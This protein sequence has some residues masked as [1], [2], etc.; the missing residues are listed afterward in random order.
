MRGKGRPQAK[1]LDLALKTSNRMEQQH[2]VSKSVT[3][4]EYTASSINHN[5]TT[6]REAPLVPSSTTYTPPDPPVFPEPEPY[7]EGADSMTNTAKTIEQITT[8]SVSELRQITQPDQTA[9]SYPDSSVPAEGNNNTSQIGQIN[10]TAT[11]PETTPDNEDTIE[12]DEPTGTEENQEN[13]DVEPPNWTENIG[14]VYDN[15]DQICEELV[16]LDTMTRQLNVMKRHNNIH[17]DPI[18]SEEDFLDEESNKITKGI[19]PEK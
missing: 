1:P 13:M 14:L 10:P 5:N 8:D 12:H 4:T 17:D 3:V 18:G 15:F 16:D 19:T 9:N 2:S 6:D 7:T 11:L